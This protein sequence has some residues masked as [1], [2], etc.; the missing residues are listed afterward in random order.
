MLDRPPA[1]TG[2]AARSR[3]NLTAGRPGAEARG[4]EAEVE[5]RAGRPAARPGAVGGPGLRQLPSPSS[6][7]GVPSSSVRTENQR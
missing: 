6:E 1:G 4:G 3:R 7:L 2:E 5:W